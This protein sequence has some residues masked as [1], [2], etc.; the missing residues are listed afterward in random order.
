MADLTVTAANVVKGTPEPTLITGIA[1]EAVTAGQPGYLDST[2]GKYMRAQSDSAVKAAAKG[3]FLNNAALDQPCDLVAAGNYNPGATVVIG[4]TYYV[5][6]TVGGIQP[7]GDVAAAE[8]VTVLGIG[9][10][11]SNIKVSINASGI[12][13]A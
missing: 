9:T 1:G 10:T 13:H 5:S 6:G 3:V 4:E 2:T 12:A 8:F 11:A 7:S